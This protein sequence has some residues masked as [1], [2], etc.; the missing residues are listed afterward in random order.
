MTFERGSCPWVDGLYADWIPERNPRCCCRPSPVSV[1]GMSW[2]VEMEGGWGASGG[3]VPSG[4]VSAVPRYR[5]WIE[6]GDGGDG[7]GTLDC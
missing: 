7:E 4:Q 6:L 1:S 5:T 2:D 3:S